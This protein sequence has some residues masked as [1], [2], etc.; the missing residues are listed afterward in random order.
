MARRQKKFSLE[1][2]LRDP[3]K[4]VRRFGH[5]QFT[6]EEEAEAR[7]FAAWHAEI[8]QCVKGASRVETQKPHRDGQPREAQVL[9]E[10]RRV[11]V[12]RVLG[13]VH[14]GGEGDGGPTRR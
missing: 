7:Y 8:K 13:P 11:D 6:T 14:G 1:I 12:E 9:V 10:G 4:K 2:I 5:V 3:D